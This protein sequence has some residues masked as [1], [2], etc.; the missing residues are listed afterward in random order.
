MSKLL[1]VVKDKISIVALFVAALIVLLANSVS[2]AYQD[3]PNPAGIVTTSFALSSSSSDR[4]KQRIK[5]ESDKP[6]RL[7]DKYAM[8]INGSPQLK[9]LV[10]VS[11]VYEV[12]IENGFKAEN[13]YV[14]DNDGKGHDKFSYP[15]DGPADKASVVRVLDHLAKIVDDLD[16]VFCYVSDHGDR[17]P[18]TAL[19][20]GFMGEEILGPYI[21]P[22]S[23][24]VLVDQ[25]MDQRE[26][27]LFVDKINPRL[28]IL[29]FTQCYSGGFA[30]EIKRKNFISVAATKANKFSYSSL[31]DSFGGYLMLAFRNKDTSDLNKDGQISLYEAFEY[32]K[33]HS[34]IVGYKKQ[35]PFISGA[36][37]PASV[38]LK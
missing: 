29:V 22:L 11:T 14:L 34:E 6:N 32:A 16:L 36:L 21:F 20:D 9:F 5:S 30:E 37:D 27:A 31:E 3:R 23:S 8:I 17:F 18:K 33:G 2:S 1:G 26:L 25:K 7:A 15:V 35:E 19:T 4:L 28:G 10:E 38:F 12:L 13:I 24:I